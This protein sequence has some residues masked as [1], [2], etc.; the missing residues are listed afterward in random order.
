[1][2]KKTLRQR[3]LFITLNASLLAIIFVLAF[4]PYVGYVPLGF[5]T[6]TT[7]PTLVILISL[8]FDWP[9]T[10]IASLGYGLSSFVISLLGAS[11][12]FNIQFQNPLISIGARLTFGV[13]LIVLVELLKKINKNNNPFIMGGFSALASLVH[14]FLVFLFF[15]V[16]QQ[17]YS[18]GILSVLFVIFG[19]GC[20]IEA[21]LSA[22]LVP[23]L[24]RYLNKPATNLHHNLTMKNEEEENTNE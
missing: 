2:K 17:G 21:V 11:D 8:L 9:E 3:I 12:P 13:A 1:M 5:A 23:L 15:I 7:I 22:V 20:L 18:E 4:I 19:I 10:L 24:Y 6:I 14:S 16:F